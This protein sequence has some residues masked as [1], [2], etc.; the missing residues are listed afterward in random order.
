MV[1]EVPVGQMPFPVW[2]IHH[3]VAC[4]LSAALVG[5]GAVY[6]FFMVRHFKA[7]EPVGLTHSQCQNTHTVSCQG[8]VLSQKKL[9]T[10]QTH[11]NSIW[12]LR[13]G[14]LANLLNTLFDIYICV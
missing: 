8:F 11:V 12:K 3:C 9:C 4:I 6:I 2:L 13:F 14:A 1:C 5:N 10:H 7:P